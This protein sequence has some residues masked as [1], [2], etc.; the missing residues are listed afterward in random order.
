MNTTKQIICVK[1]G[2][3]YGPEYVNRLYAMV[4]RHT[5][6]PIRLIC[7]TD[8]HEGLRPEVESFD[9]PELG[10][11]HPQRTHGKWKKVVLWGRELHGLTGT[12]LFV[13]L[14]S[15]IVDSLDPYFSYGS[16]DDVLLARNWAKP[17]QRLG[18]TSVFRFPIG[19]NPH[20]LDNFR[21]DPQGTADRFH[22]EQHY[23][24]SSV[25]GGIKLWP[26]AWTRH[27]RLHCML[28]FPFRYFFQARLPR[29]SRIV[30]FPGGP[31]PSDVML[32]RWV[33]E[34]PAHESRWDHIRGA[35]K[36]GMTLKARWRHFTR[37]V[38]PPQWIADNWRE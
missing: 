2:T 20:I 38:I 30:T 10:C 31:N 37:Y 7:L 32:G 26:E 25:T 33:P 14:D 18:Q 17:F 23:I 27:F 34:A 4:R 16:P 22:Y 1:W 12:A 11:E 19:K 35:F 13:D 9:L 5:T 28:P 29:G 36:P 24:T 8:N 15:V 21:A 6:G 3:M